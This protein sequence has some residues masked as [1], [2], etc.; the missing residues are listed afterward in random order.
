MKLEKL[1]SGSYRVR[2]TI[3]HKT[4]TLIYDH[5]P[6]KV[7]LDRDIAKLYSSAKKKDV[8]ITFKEAAKVYVES[9]KNVLSPRTVKE[10]TETPQR[11]SEGFVSLP[12]DKITQLD[13]QTE[14]NALAKTKSPKTV[15]NY[16]AFISSVLRLYYPDLIINTTLPLKRKNE[17]YIPS[18]DDVKKVLAYVKEHK[19]NFYACLVLAAYGLRRSEILAITADDVDGNILTINKAKVLNSDKKWV[20]KGTKTTESERKLTIPKDIAKEIKKNGYAFNCYPNDIYKVLKKACEASNVPV[21]SMHKLRHYFASK[22][23]SENVDITTVMALGGWQSPAVLQKHYAHAM[24]KK[25]KDALDIITKS[26][27]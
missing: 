6:N 25:K 9:K 23:L 21:F 22:L 1:P 27:S 3:E 17:P 20:I 2:K 13:I 8:K 19:P 4:H 16:H 11:L 24:E 15:R 12:L 18:E 5:K 26:L 7:E 10:Y 14:I